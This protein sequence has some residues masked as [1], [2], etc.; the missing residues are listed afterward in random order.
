MAASRLVQVSGG[1]RLMVGLRWIS[2]NPSLPVSFSARSRRRR[3]QP[4]RR[5][6]FP[7]RDK[8]ASSRPLRCKFSR[9]P[10]SFA[11]LRR[12]EREAQRNIELMWLTGRLAPDFKTIADFRIGRAH[13]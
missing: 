12:L 2:A 10:R 13:V 7:G 9:L 1:I 8:P 5:K 3:R 11:V 6:N 4:L